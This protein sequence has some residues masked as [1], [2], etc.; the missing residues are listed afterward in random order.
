MASHMANDTSMANH[1]AND[2]LTENHMKNDISLAEFPANGLSMTQ[3]QNPADGISTDP[4]Y[5]SSKKHL[6]YYAN[7][8]RAVFGALTNSC[9][10]G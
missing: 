1:A 2:I 4:D 9:L 10:Q 3:L 7:P 8:H 5:H 6:L